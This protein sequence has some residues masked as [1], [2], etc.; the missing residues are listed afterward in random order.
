MLDRSLASRTTLDGRAAEEFSEST[1]TA[2]EAPASASNTPRAGA[3][4]RDGGATSG[5]A[6]RGRAAEGRV[7]AGATA[8]ALGCSNA[9]VGPGTGALDGYTGVMIGAAVDMGVPAGDAAARVS[10]A[11]GACG[12]CRQAQNAAAEIVSTMP[13]A[14]AGFSQAALAGACAGLLTPSSPKME[15]AT[16]R[17]VETAALRAGSAT[18]GR[19]ETCAVAAAAA[20]AEAAAAA[21]AWG[22]GADGGSAEDAPLAAGSGTVA[23]ECGR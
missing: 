7:I 9:G 6:T 14:R 21:A 20:E 12:W 22:G 1:G 2:R 16:R 8:L 13:A 3:T 17:G 18:E 15:N 10:V 19:A 5:E 11:A 4:A 23:A